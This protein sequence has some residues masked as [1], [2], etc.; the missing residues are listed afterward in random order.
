MQKFRWNMPNYG[1][2]K[3]PH[4][5][6]TIIMLSVS[7]FFYE[8]AHHINLDN[9]NKKKI[10]C[11][12]NNNFQLESKCKLLHSQTD[13]IVVFMAFRKFYPKKKRANT[14]THLKPFTIELSLNLDWWG[15]Q[16]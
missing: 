13:T 6:I 10:W 14:Y 9:E 11:I 5:H 1:K 4:T 7:E 8:T 16:N 15:F 12:V 3:Q 2:K